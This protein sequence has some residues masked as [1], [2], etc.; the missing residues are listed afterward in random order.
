MCGRTI[1]RVGDNNSAFG[2]MVLEG[3]RIKVNNGNSTNYCNH[4]WLGDLNLKT[5]FPKK[6]KLESVIPRV[7]TS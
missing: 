3:F 4:A 2:Q 7:P 6:Q 5:M 1:C